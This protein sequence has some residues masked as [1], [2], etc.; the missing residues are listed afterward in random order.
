MTDIDR[1]LEEVRELM[2]AKQ[3]GLRTISHEGEG[4]NFI[5]ERCGPDDT[6]IGLRRTTGKGL[7][8]STL[9]VDE[10]FTA[11]RSLYPEQFAPAAS[12]EPTEA[13]SPEVLPFTFKYTDGRPDETILAPVYREPSQLD[14]IEQAIKALSAKVS[15][16]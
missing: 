9:K 14:R 8:V 6:L 1:Y 12:Q 5:L 15:N 7:Q 13:G 16:E 4:T 10:F 3:R 2:R 11:L